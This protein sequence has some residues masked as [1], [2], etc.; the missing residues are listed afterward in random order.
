MNTY[1]I[2]IADCL[3]IAQETACYLNQLLRFISV[4]RMATIFKFNTRS[5]APVAQFHSIR[6]RVP[7]VSLIPCTAS[8]GHFIVSIS[9]SIV[10]IDLSKLDRLIHSS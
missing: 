6:S 8:N 7:N 4:R 5:A 2:D 3:R 1:V 9:S 10:P